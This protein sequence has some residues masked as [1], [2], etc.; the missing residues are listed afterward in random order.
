[1]EVI[2]LTDPALC[3][4]VY[5]LSGPAVI[6]LKIVNVDVPVYNKHRD[7]AW[8]STEEQRAYIKTQTARYDRN[9]IRLY[10]GWQAKMT[11]RCNE[12]GDMEKAKA[13][14]GPKVVRQAN[15]LYYDR[16]WRKCGPRKM[17][18]SYIVEIYHYWRDISHVLIRKQFDHL[19]EYVAEKRLPVELMTVPGEYQPEVGRS[20][21]LTLRRPKPKPKPETTPEL[22]PEP[23]PELKPEPSPETEE[24][25]IDLWGTW[26]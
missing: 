6:N 4:R 3:T 19:W 15:I 13:D 10:Q 24:D 9:L 7:G 11:R 12:L 2:R 16:I 17:T 21:S 1:M 5:D 8:P 22:K 14:A 20:W 26:K 18:K 23:Q 25:L